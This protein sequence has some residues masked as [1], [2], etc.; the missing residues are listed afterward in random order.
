LFLANVVGSLIEL[1]CEFSRIVREMGFL[2]S[3]SGTK[4]AATIVNV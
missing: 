3:N 4:F 1:E 2:R